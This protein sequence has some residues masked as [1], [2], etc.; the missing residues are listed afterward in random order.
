MPESPTPK[1][2]I[3]ISDAEMGIK[4][5]DGHEGHHIIKNLREECP[6]ASCTNYGKTKAATVSG[7][8]SFTIKEVSPVG[9][10]AINIVWGDGHDTGIY[11]FEQLRKICQCE[12]C[13]KK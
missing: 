2:I 11:T 1:E 5:S 13:V 6:C 9:R 3:K 7:E 10:Y 8:T 12:T 4:W